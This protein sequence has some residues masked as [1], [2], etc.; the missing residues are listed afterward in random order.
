MSFASSPSRWQRILPALTLVLFSPLV[1][2]V[3][4]GSTRFAAMFVFP[5]EMCVWGGGA[6]LIR[7]AIR[8]WRL[9][10]GNMLLLALSLAIAEECLIQQTSLAPMFL[11]LKGEPYAR[12]FGLNYIWFLWALGYHSVYAVFLPVYLVELIYPNRRDAVWV[13]KAGLIVTVLF[14]F[15]GCYFA[16]YTWTQIARPI[17]FK[18]P[19][20]NPPGTD[21]LIA[22]LTIAGLVFAALGPF[23]RALARSIEPWKTPSPWLLG[24]TGF[25]S[26]IL[27]FGLVLLGL[28]IAPRFPP[29]LAVSAGLILAIIVALSVPRWAADIRF[30]PEHQFAL[31][32]GAMLGSMTV[33]YLRF[34]G[35]PTMDLYFKFIVD[36]V[37]IALMV[38]LRFKITRKFEPRHWMEEA[39]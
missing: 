27:W 20:Y 1:E 7:A 33:G 3:L 2:E 25:V 6:L 37:A 18:V 15:V 19:K 22:S 30:Q 34:L 4:S 35:P 17:V 12:A 11:Q 9:G 38:A 29:A 14:F 8:R 5:I 31:V 28:G 32:F 24:I 39:I 23:R 36:L 26:A 16:W 10:W 21:V 13:N